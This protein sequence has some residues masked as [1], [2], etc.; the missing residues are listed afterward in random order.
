MWGGFH[1]IGWNGFKSQ[2]YETLYHYFLSKI[3]VSSTLT[4]T[5]NKLI[6]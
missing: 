6:E 4:Q 2:E 3:N 5:N 1:S